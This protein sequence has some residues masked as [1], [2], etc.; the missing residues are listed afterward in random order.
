M[1]LGEENEYQEFKESL[2][3]LDKGLKSISAMLNKHGRGTVYFGVA[4][5]GEVCGVV[6]GKNTLMDIRNRIADKIDPRIYAEIKDYKDENQKVYVKVTA[7]G[8][9]APYSFDGRYYYRNVS[10]DEQATNAILRKMLSSSD[11]DVIK[12]QESPEQKLTFKTLFSLLSA[13]SKHPN[14]TEEFYKNYCLLNDEAKFNMNA[15]LLA[16]ENNIS[17]KVV[18][19]NG[20]DKSIM[21]NR[22]EYG[23]KSLLSVVAEVSEFFNS[24][25]TTNVDV[26]SIQREE[27]SLFDSASF[28]EA[29]INAC[30]HNDWKNAIAPA[31]YLFDDRIEVVSYGGIPFTLTKEGFY[32]GTSVPVNKSLLTIFMACGYAEQTGHGIPTIVEKYGRNAFSFDDGILKVTI[33]L[34]FKRPDVVVRESV[35]LL[36]NKSNL[37]ENQRKVYEAL[38]ENGKRPLA[39]IAKATGL[40]IAGVKKICSKLQEYKLIERL[41]SKKTGEWIAK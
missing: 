5:N 30:L 22:T 28:R 2:S 29:W 20:L 37:T 25:N 8:S 27:I 31:V 13:N 19:F 40:S 14:N 21:S 4:D 18:T 35:D 12:H 15:Y 26:T 3:Q 9:D 34:A 7:Y 41:G 1:N 32:N 39:E 24:I 38:R 11:S 10:A 36:E 17:I 16:D 6:L 23:N 33:P